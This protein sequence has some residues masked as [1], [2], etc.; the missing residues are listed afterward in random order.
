MI[1]II[2][3]NIAFLLDYFYKIE[4]VFF[5]LTSYHGHNVTCF[6]LQLQQMTWYSYSSSCI[7]TYSPIVLKVLMVFVFHFQPTLAL[8]LLFN[9]YVIDCQR[10]SQKMSV[11]RYIHSWIRT[12]GSDSQYNIEQYRSSQNFFLSCLCLY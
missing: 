9:I 5:Y 11:Q 7:F 6:D 4:R 12:G 2:I 10:S 1:M 3:I 8:M